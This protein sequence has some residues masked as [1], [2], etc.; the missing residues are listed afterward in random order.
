VLE[1]RSPGTHIPSS[2]ILS[3]PTFRNPTRIA[4]MLHLAANGG[5]DGFDATRRAVGIAAQ[6]LSQQ[7]NVLAQ[8]GY[9]VRDRKIIGGLAHTELILTS[10]GRDAL[11]AI[12]ATPRAEAGLP[13]ARGAP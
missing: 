4:I 9:V 13:M 8:A 7:A 2:E 6:T 3:D 11:A 1:L 10:P 12:E 5:R